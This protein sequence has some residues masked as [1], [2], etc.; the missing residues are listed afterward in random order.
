M[1]R[2]TRINSKFLKLNLRCSSTAEKTSPKTPEYLKLDQ[3]PAPEI[4]EFPDM[5]QFHAHHAGAYN[6]IMKDHKSDDEKAKTSIPKNYIEENEKS[7]KNIKLFEEG[8]PAWAQP[9]LQKINLAKKYLLWHFAK[10]FQTK[11][12]SFHDIPD[13]LPMVD[14]KTVRRIELENPEKAKQIK[15][16]VKADLIQKFAVGGMFFEIFGYFLMMISVTLAFVG[17][18][19]FNNWAEAHIG[20]SSMSKSEFFRESISVAWETSSL[21]DPFKFS[22]AMMRYRS[23]VNDTYN[24]DGTLNKELGIAHAE[25]K[26]D[27][28]PIVKKY[29]LALETLKS[30]T[31]ISEHNDGGG[32][33]EESDLDKLT[34]LTVKSKTE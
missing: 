15:A 24:T 31:N 20:N 6:K 10:S 33:L 22:A 29:A 27:Q 13:Y 7:G 28:E 12:K 26:F 9:E 4:R 23:T 25:F 18:V 11:Y 16:K 14:R 1:L 2:L 5:D 19:K 30:R 21:T 34:S 32:W 17:T 3:T 8:R